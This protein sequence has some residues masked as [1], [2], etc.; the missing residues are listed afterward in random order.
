MSNVTIVRRIYVRGLL[1][2]VL[3]GGVSGLVLALPTFI[4]N[5]LFGFV[6][7]AMTGL[8][9]GSVIG[10][11]AGLLT[12]LL[13]SPIRSVRAYRITIAVIAA[14]IAGFAARE[15]GLAYAPLDNAAAPDYLRVVPMLLAIVLAVPVSQRLIGWYIKETTE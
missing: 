11:A 6:V 9:A 7:G 2:G 8:I 4:D 15:V 10:L 5:A 14:I 1:W 13:F 3:A 12:G